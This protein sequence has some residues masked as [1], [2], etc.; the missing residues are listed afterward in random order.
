MLCVITDKYWLR[1]VEKKLIL[2][3]PLFLE[4]VK[5][6]TLLLSKC[7]REKNVLNIFNNIP[8]YR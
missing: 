1:M 3:F 2:P 4:K 5:K 7:M 6:V 8:A